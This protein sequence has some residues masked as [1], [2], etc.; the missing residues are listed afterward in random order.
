ML[1]NVFSNISN[2]FG[3]T[4]GLNEE[5]Q[6]LY[7]KLGKIYKDHKG[8]ISA[9]NAE[10]ANLR[11]KYEGTDIAAKNYLKTAQYATTGAK[12]FTNTLKANAKAMLKARATTFVYNAALS[13]LASFI[14][15]VVYT[16]IHSVEERLDA[17]TDATTEF[18]D[19]IQTLE[20]SFETYEKLNGVLQDE[21]STTE[22]LNTAKEQL[23][24]LQNSLVDAYGKEAA[25]LD[26]V[27]GKYEEQIK[28]LSEMRR[29][30]AQEYLRDNRFNLNTL[31]NEM[32]KDLD[33]KIGDLAPIG[34]SQAFAN[35]VEEIYGKHDALV[36][37]QTFFGEDVGR[38]ESDV[39]SARD[40]LEAIY[41][42]FNDLRD[43][44]TSDVE[45]TFVDK[46]LKKI[47]KQI[48]AWD[49]EYAE[50]YDAYQT[51]AGY[52]VYGT[53]NFAG[54][55]GQTVSPSRVY[56]EYIEAVE[57][58]NA[59]LATGSREV[60]TEAEANLDSAKSAANR[61]IEEARNSGKFSENDISVMSDGFAEL[62]NEIDH[63]KA[64]Q[65]ELMFAM[66]DLAD[67]DVSTSN[68]IT[69]D[70]GKILLSDADVKK[71]KDMK[72][73][74]TEFESYMHSTAGTQY[75][76]RLSAVADEYGVSI[77][78]VLELLA[79]LGILSDYESPISEEDIELFEEYGDVIE[80][81]I[82]GQS[83]YAS[84]TDT[85]KA[86]VDRFNEAAE[87]RNMLTADYLT[88]HKEAQAKSFADALSASS[89]ATDKLVTATDDAV[90]VMEDMDTIA[91]VVNKKMYL[92]GEEAADLASRHEEL[93][94]ALKWTT[95]G[96]TLES[97]AMDLAKSAS[98]SL[99]SAYLTAQKNMTTLCN[100]QVAQRLK[101]YKIELTSMKSLASAFAYNSPLLTS[102]GEIATAK[103]G[104]RLGLDINSLKT[105]AGQRFLER[106]QK[107]NGGQPL[108]QV[109]DADADEIAYTQ[110][111]I[112]QS[113]N[114]A[115]IEKY[116]AE[117]AKLSGYTASSGG[118]KVEKY[119]ADLDPLYK[120]LE[121]QKRVEED[122]A[123]IQRERE[124]LEEDDFD[125]RIRNIYKEIGAL[126][127]LNLVLQEQ[128][129]I[130]KGEIEKRIAE[131]RKYG[132][133]VTYN[134]E[135]NEVLVDNYE[136][137][138]VIAY[139]YA[140]DTGLGA[141]AT[142]TLVQRIETLIDETHN[143]ND[144]NRDT[145]ATWNDN[146]QAVKDYTE[147]IKNLKTEMVDDYLGKKENYLSH[148]QDFELW[149]E[150]QTVE[151][152]EE[153]LH[154]LEDFYNAGL[155]DYE[156]FVEEYQS[157]TKRIYDSRKESLETIL[158]MIEDLVRQE[159]EDQ[160]DA[161]E[162][163]KDALN[164]IIEAKK[165]IIG[166]TKTENDYN[167]S[168]EDKIKEMARLQERI[169]QLELDDSREAAAEKAGLI[170]QL[171][172][173]QDEV[174]SMQYD[175]S[176]ELQEEALDEMQENEEEAI[177]KQIEKIE[178]MADDAS[179]VHDMVIEKLQGDWDELYDALVQWN[180]IYGSGV[181]ADVQQPWENATEALK[182]YRDEL[183]KIT[184][185][186]AALG[187][188]NE[189]MP[190][191]FDTS[192]SIIADAHK[193]E[194]TNLVNQMRSNSAKWPTADAVGRTAL[195]DENDAIAAQIAQITGKS[196]VRKSDGVWY[197]D[198]KKLYDEYPVFH[199]GGTVGSKK[200]SEVFS[201]L[202][203]GEDVLTKQHKFTA[204]P[205]LQAGI[206]ALNLNEN[207]AKILE[208]LQKNAMPSFAALN[209]NEP[210]I[211]FAPEINIE[212]N[213]GS[214]AKEI[215]AATKD[216]VWSTV[217]DPFRKMGITSKYRGIKI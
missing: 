195:E 207:T 190:S 84:L 25:G 146:I 36:I 35:A 201:L 8:N 162:D 33:F 54:S 126:E 88:L 148:M 178:E 212:V 97:D 24:T 66:Q 61:V 185:A 169:A 94:D 208:A 182:I 202:E 192:D 42:D 65:Q 193:A 159:L 106:A 217:V 78:R 96:W 186:Q 59:A 168:L 143:L 105:E 89:S 128:N 198:G 68:F 187:T 28:L 15:N 50:T 83:N 117:M 206:Q 205:L 216:A 203:Q 144:A 13:L 53:D 58:Y 172:Q 154:D 81:I 69:S 199:T 155:I 135:A 177:D 39:K 158:D 98:A 210:A 115:A 19:E 86:A 90:D 92:T 3:A 129:K 26:L 6:A 145:L 27:N 18:K 181:E 183:G 49:E 176:I 79:Q 32:N 120:A 108:Y 2:A 114:L 51:Y 184:T 124:G 77:S 67:N 116:E 9:V 166:L 142:N 60:I 167:K 164:D 197:I 70:T 85:E 209:S 113:E 161:Y 76:N 11:E 93:G 45:I 179:L 4:Y 121:K 10:L 74:I 189:F 150:A 138:N 127:S 56:D 136:N 17:V 38:F 175:K 7:D 173:L 170:D 180:A 140:K 132:M 82:N 200:K 211:H 64:N 41:E 165:K 118:S 73:S 5:Q 23:L 43:A 133:A 149:D 153:M 20:D 160:V 171:A 111:L 103:D 213:A 214:D 87:K 95:E 191:V 101:M 14:A 141:E 151:Y 110:F 102:T 100:T 91:A 44:A 147:E 29:D 72:L 99:Q 163:Q 52:A 80:K 62:A 123:D 112:Q 157:I 37:D 196:V 71:I 104:T 215:A 174:D 194:I 55:D 130:R 109:G 107:E 63:A 75:F 122:I 12:D 30:K 156:K 57:E 31:T 1:N 46:M 21:T 134:A 22:E 16:A 34:G 139:T 137:L 188:V 125:G 40:Q 48:S 119:L 47:S 152:L 131:L 204:I